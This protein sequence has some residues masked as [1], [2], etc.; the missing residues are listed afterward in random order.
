[1]STYYPSQLVPKTN[2]SKAAIAATLQ[3]AFTLHQ[4]GRIEQ[5]A[6]LYAKI[7]EVEPSHFDALHL[8]GI[9]ASQRKKPQLAVD[10]ISRAIQINPNNAA[11]YSNLGLALQDL[12]RNEEALSNYELALLIEPENTAVVFNQANAF[13]DLGR[14]EEALASYD[15]LLQLVPNDAEALYYSGNVLRELDR[16]T[17]ALHRYDQALKVNPAYLAAHINRGVVLQYLNR[18]ED[19]LASYDRALRIASDN[20]EALYNRAN[21]LGALNRPEEALNSYD[22]VLRLRP[23]HPEVLNNRGNILRALTRLDEAIASLAR[24]QAV[25]PN[26]ADARWNESLCRLL[27]GDFEKGLP[28]YEAR[29][30][31]ELA[32]EKRQ[33]TKPLWLGKESLQNK[34]ILIHAEQGFGDTL[35]F[36]RYVTKVFALGPKIILEV[37]PALKRLLGSLSGMATVIAKG[38]SLPAYDFHCPLLSLPLA[39]AT[40]LASIPA[41]QAYLSSDS[42]LVAQWQ[43]KLGLSASGALNRKPRVGVVW[44]GS[45]GKDYKTGKGRSI[46]LV[47][48]S[49]LF[50]QPA[51]FY[52]LQKEISADELQILAQYDNVSVFNRE[53]QDFADTAALIEHMDLVVSIDTSVAHLAAAMGKPVWILLRYSPDWRWLLD[54]PD[55]P[56]YPSARLFRQT[57]IGH[58]TNVLDEVKRA[59]LLHFEGVV[60]LT[61]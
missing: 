1:M 50:D 40:D 12:G 43:S 25:A 49:Q 15:H 45:G 56:W 37:Q 7:L 6:A 10:L 23:D 19:A 3:D 46:D 51:H 42:R 34:T 38:E 33:F 26:Y 17:D 21:V 55:S 32:H 61:A 48:F 35:Q 36:C 22:K 16:H 53:L 41:E 5:A 14:H 54:R 4:Q 24:A 59:L 47:E 9:A 29:W 57:E 52:V 31:S 44:D 60:A 18:N 2:L 20:V 58:W 8:S 13:R 27:A 39:F 28:A 30:D 11:V